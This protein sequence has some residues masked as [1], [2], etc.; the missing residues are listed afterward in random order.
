MVVMVNSE[1]NRMSDS[2]ELIRMLDAHIEYAENTK[3]YHDVGNFKGI[4][5]YIQEQQKQL[6]KRH[7]DYKIQVN[8][9]VDL[10]DKLTAKEKEIEELLR[11]QSSVVE[12]LENENTYRLWS[13]NEAK[14]QE[15]S[16]L[17]TKEQ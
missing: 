17:L 13:E 15:L 12:L 5:F 1:G 3:K 10:Q 6:D 2:K 7:E 4:K 8:A 11:L 14:A 16:N 9:I